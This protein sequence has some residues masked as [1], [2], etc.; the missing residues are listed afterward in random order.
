[1]KVNNADAIFKKLDEGEKSSKFIAQANARY[2]L[3]GVNEP[4]EN[5]PKSN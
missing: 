5:F 1:M 2:I 4:V 3:F